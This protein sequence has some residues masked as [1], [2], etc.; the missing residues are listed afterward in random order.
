MDHNN[1]IK[2]L[3]TFYIHNKSLHIVMEFVDGVDLDK[4]VK[5][6]EHGYLSWDDP[7]TKTIVMQLCEAV[8]YL[9][10]RSQGYQAPK[11]HDS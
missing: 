5:Q 6:T 8:T 11:W 9:R 3:D 1:I 7:K 4:H 2:F 10:L